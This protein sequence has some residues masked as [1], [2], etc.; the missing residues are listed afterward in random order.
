M[1]VDPFEEEAGAQGDYI[2]SVF[3]ENGYLSRQFEGYR[4]RP[5]QIALARA[6]EAGIAQGKHVMAEGPTGT[7][8]SIAYAVPAAFHAAKHGRKIV[9][10]TAN[11]ALTE[12]LAHKD[13]PLLQ[14]ILPWKF[15]FALIKG[16]SNYLCT[17]RLLQSEAERL[18][19][20]GKNTGWG[21]SEDEQTQVAKINQWAETTNTGDTSEL[22]F[23]PDGN[24]WRMFSRGSDECKGNK[25]KSFMNCFAYTAKRAARRADIIVTNYHM[26]FAALNVRR[27]TGRNV[28][29]PGFDVVICD[30][31]HE[32]AEIARNFFGFQ[33]TAGRCRRVASDLEKIEDDW[34]AKELA[35]KVRNA[36]QGFYEALGEYKKKAGYKTRLKVKLAEDRE[37]GERWKWLD[38]L[39][40]E[41]AYKLRNMRGN[42]QDESA[43]WEKASMRAAELR[44]NIEAAV[45]LE[46]EEDSVYFLEEER[47]EKA[48]RV[49]L[50]S[51]PIHVSARIRAEL[52]DAS[53]KGTPRVSSTYGE[54]SEV[55]WDEEDEPTEDEIRERKLRDFRVVV[56]TSAT[57]TTDGTFAYC[58]RETGA[59]SYIEVI[60]ESPFDW[61]NQGLLIVP[62]G[63]PDPSL[64]RE[65]FAKAVPEVVAEAIRLARGRTL[66]LFTSNKAV[67][68]SHTML[69]QIKCPYKLLKQGDM[70]RM[71]LIEAFKNDLQ[72]C[73][74]GTTSLWT[75][76]DV[77]GEACS[78]VIID[79]IPFTTPDDP[80][81]DAIAAKDKD[82]FNKYSIP[83]AIIRLKQGI[84]RLIRSQGDRGVV[85]LC[86]PRVIEKKYGP[87]FIKSFPPM[88]RSRN[89]A[90]IGDFLPEP[91]LPPAGES[92][93]TPFEQEI[94]DSD[95]YDDVSF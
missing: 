69:R 54:D 78:L 77:P 94:N 44:S 72:S 40:D 7:G 88:A 9:I 93:P 62:M 8:K 70:P 74:L 80:V 4:P 26:L 66:A 30:E 3:G 79:K 14:E 1:S 58:A 31:S 59:H 27:L 37:I 51:K 55:E 61:E 53:P 6:V 89:L 73:L 64:D 29:L 12:Q 38:K 87:K 60:A 36:G 28:L 65:K 33:T 18:V 11:I 83:M 75:G 35:D 10:V 19:Q 56:Q 21:L 45:K 46:D 20:I 22:D 85:V 86:D 91:S 41:A 81:I 47:G 95:Y 2:E 84:G 92:A 5:G 82:W 63:L 50:G 25:C 49:I 52:Y 15:K 32:M 68:E 43:D 42:S 48:S 76:V 13:L 17:D 24:I 34:R 23:V 90:H 67:G 57:I 39:L 16:R 71:R